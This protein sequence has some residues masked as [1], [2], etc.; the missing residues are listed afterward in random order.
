MRMPDYIQ[1]VFKDIKTQPTRSIL[2]I[3]AIVISSALFLTLVSLGVHTRSAIVS[4]ITNGDALSMVLV[5]SNSASGSG[6]FTNSVQVARTQ[7]EKIDDAVVEKIAALPHVSLAVPQVSVWELSRFNVGGTDKSFVANALA[8]SQVAQDSTPLAA[9]TWFAGSSQEPEIILGNGYMRA[10]GITDPQRL[11]GSTITFTTVKGYRGIDASIPAWNAS[12]SQRQQFTTQ[13]TQLTGRIVGVTTPSARDNQL[14]VPLS[15][16]QLVQSPR[17]STPSGE[18]S[19]DSI[20]KN[21]YTTVLVKAENQKYVADIAH[22]I[23]TL[24]YGATTYQK[25]IDQINQLSVVMWIV[26]GAVAI[27]SLISASLGI[28]NTLLMALSEQKK[29][30]Q[31]W[32]ACGASRSLVARLYVMQAV[33]IGLI[34]GSLGAVIGWIVTTQLNSRISYVL[35]SQGLES[36]ALPGV[37][38]VMLVGTVAL[39]TLLAALA[40]VIP[41]YKAS[42]LV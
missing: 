11:I 24:G 17:A 13:S 30:I 21:G 35:S 40:A 6:L 4:H 3:S 25:Q 20:A 23:E 12:T 7:T 38:P 31:I 9:G 39:T 33:A 18:T 22:S 2:T 14:F 37:S 41:A 10:L 15:W 1:T 8:T 26:L 34:G 36:L 5:S 27:I 32:R 19:E 42:R 28:I 29:T 16:A